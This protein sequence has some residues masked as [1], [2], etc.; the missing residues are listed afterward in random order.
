MACSGTVL[1]FYFL[2]ADVLLDS[3]EHVDCR[4]R[5]TVCVKYWENAGKEDDKITSKVTFIFS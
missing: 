2:L 5:P 1:L 3:G 4:S